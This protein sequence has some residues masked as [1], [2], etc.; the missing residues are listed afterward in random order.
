MDIPDASMIALVEKLILDTVRMENAAV[1]L[2]LKHKALLALVG[3]LISSLEGFLKDNSK[4]EVTSKGRTGS[5]DADKWTG[6][7]STKIS[8]RLSQISGMISSDMNPDGAPLTDED[9]LKIQDE[10]STLGSEAATALEG[11][12]AK[13]LDAW[14]RIDILG[15]V[16]E[17]QSDMG[18][19]VKIENGRK[20][21]GSLGGNLMDGSFVIMEDT[22]SG[23][24]TT[25]IVVPGADGSPQLVTQNNMEGATERQIALNTEHIR[26]SLEKKGIGMPSGNGT[27]LGH[28]PLPELGSASSLSDKEGAEVLRGH[29]SSDGK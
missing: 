24:S 25:F 23:E 19:V 14:E 1:A 26:R 22:L 12:A 4:V 16:A 5:V 20:A 8:E 9:V 17:C 28:K 18:R 29:L 15:Q 2:S 6:G 11:A 13:V 10:V 21:M 7:Q 27:C 3:G